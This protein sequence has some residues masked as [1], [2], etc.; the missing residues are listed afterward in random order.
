MKSRLSVTVRLVYVCSFLDQG[1]DQPDLKLDDGQVKWATVDASTHIDVDFFRIDQD[2]GCSELFISNCQ[3]KRRAVV[4]VQDV[5]VS[6]PLQQ[7]LKHTIVSLGCRIVQRGPLT[8]VLVV[9]L[10]VIHRVVL[11]E[12]D[13]HAL[14]HVVPH[15]QVEQLLKRLK[16]VLS[17]FGASAYDFRL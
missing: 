13:K 16:D 7:S 10:K 17:V 4:F 15:K 6:V 5:R 1:F 11:K 3:A 9:H 12:N 8:I 14:V 2:L